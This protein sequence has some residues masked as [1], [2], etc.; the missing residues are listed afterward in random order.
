MDQAEFLYTLI[1]VTVSSHIKSCVVQMANGLMWHRFAVHLQ[2]HSSSRE[3]T[4]TT[5]SMFWKVLLLKN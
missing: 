2:R 3:E 1:E 4:T 5:R